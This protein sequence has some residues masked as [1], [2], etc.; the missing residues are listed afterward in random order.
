MVVARVFAD[1]ALRFESVAAELAPAST[2]PREP[3]GGAGPAVSL[4]VGGGRTGNDS[5]GDNNSWL[6]S[7]TVEPSI[8]C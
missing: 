2:D 5:V 4:E 6:H 7:Y 8:P 3:G 1:Y